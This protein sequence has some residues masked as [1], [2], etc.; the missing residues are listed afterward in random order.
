[1]FLSQ[2]LQKLS[3]RQGLALT[4]VLVVSGWALPVFIPAGQG[5]NSVYAQA[6][7][8]LLWALAL[9]VAAVTGYSALRRS[10][11]RRRFDSDMNLGALTWDDFEGY[12]A[13]YYRRRGASVT[14]R[15][16]AGSDGGVDL[17]LDDASGRRIVQAKHWKTRRVGI[18]PLRALWG[19]RDDERA[20]GAV[21][22]TSGTFTPEALRFAE[23]KR[24][25]LIDGEQLNRVVAELKNA[26]GDASTLARPSVGAER[27]PQCGEGNLTRRLARKGPRAGSHFIGCSRWPQCK[28]TRDA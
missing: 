4:A 1:M 20:Q 14:Y 21:F 22:V 2:V 9:F 23:G 16:G 7:Q 27:C 13:E 19:V 25:E 28:Y 15:G 5:W 24:L 12:L 26:G 10:L 3:L 6:G 17:V 11:D 18:V 8:S